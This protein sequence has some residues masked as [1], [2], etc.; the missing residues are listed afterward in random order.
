MDID[1]DDDVDC[2]P[3]MVPQ[4]PCN[5][6][7]SE[8]GTNSG[9]E[10]TTPGSRCVTT[11]V[12]GVTNTFTVGSTSV[13]E[14][15][16]DSTAVTN[17]IPVGSI[18]VSEVGMESTDVTNTIPVGVSSVTGVGTESTGGSSA[19]L[20]ANSN[21]VGVF[22]SPEVGTNY[23]LSAARTTAA[24]AIAAGANTIGVGTGSGEPGR[25]STL[26]SATS[27]VQPSDGT[28][29]AINLYR[30][31]AGTAPN[32]LGGAPLPNSAAGS[33]FNGNQARIDRCSTEWH[34]GK[35]WNVMTSFTPDTLE[36]GC[37]T[38]QTRILERRALSTEEHLSSLI[39]T[40]LLQLHLAPGTSNA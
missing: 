5:T 17:T 23:T 29:L 20:N 12:T 30:R 26:S 8:V 35:K 16:T 7:S 18:S 2:K 13:S 3:A 10:G 39:S 37:C 14:V 31:H 21:A 15:G 22:C 1:D 11:A 6:I 27:P 40:L 36:C 33:L 9:A 32:L 38:E 34:F 19:I 24:R 28:Y 25:R 4:Q